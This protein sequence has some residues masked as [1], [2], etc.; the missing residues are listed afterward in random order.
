[1]RT[2][3]IFAAG[4]GTRLQPLTN[5]KPKALVELCGKTLL[6]RTVDKITRYG[7]QKIIV[8]IHHFPELMREAIDGLD[9]NGATLIVSDET[10]QL[11]DTGGGLL[12]AKQWIKGNEPVLIHNVDI[13]SDIDLGV[14]LNDHMKNNALATLAVSDRETSRYFLWHRKRLCGWE[15]VKTGAIIKTKGS[16]EE[17]NRMAFS[18]IHIIDPAIF[19]LITEQGTFS[20]NKIY[21]RLAENHKII[22]CEHDPSNWFD[23]GTMEKLQIAEEMVHLNPQKFG[24]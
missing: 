16:P 9:K 11:L 19:D 22:A 5:E 2:A 23:L 20:I 7:I 15:N 1:M 17:C 10:H 13:V 6:Q 12:K 14:L 21:L 3:M 4:K 18:G 24:S 8:N